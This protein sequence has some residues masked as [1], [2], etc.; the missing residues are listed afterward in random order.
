MLM[1]A[2]EQGPPVRSAPDDMEAFI[3]PEEDDRN[4]HHRAA[5]RSEDPD[6][7][8]PEEGSSVIRTQ[9]EET[10]KAICRRCGVMQEC[11]GWALESGQNYGVW[12]GLSEDER[13]A[14]KRRHAGRNRL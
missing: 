13:R 12:G 10:A 2:M 4:W 5:C 8:F 1:S 11:L 6:I 3:A 7:F 9:L 14:L